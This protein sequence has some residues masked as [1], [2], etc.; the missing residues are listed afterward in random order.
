[1]LSHGLFHAIPLDYA[2]PLTIGTIIGAQFGVRIAKRT[3]QKTLKMI[4]SFVA[5]LF[6]IRLILEFLLA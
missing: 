3:K 4:L 6:S 1:V 5:L 2:L